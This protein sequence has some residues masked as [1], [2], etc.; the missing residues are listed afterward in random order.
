[1]LTQRRSRSLEF[2]GLSL[3]AFLSLNLDF[4][5]TAGLSF[6]IRPSRRRDQIRFRIGV[7]A[8]AFN[9]E[10]A[11]AER[12]PHLPQQTEFIVAARVLA[13]LLQRVLQPFL[14]EE[15]ARRVVRY[16][17]QTC[18]IQLL[19]D[20]DGFQQRFIFISGPPFK[21]LEELRSKL[22]DI[23]IARAEQIEVRIVEWACDLL[24]F[25]HGDS[26]LL[27]RDFLINR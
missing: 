24:A 7:T 19:Q 22:P 2:R 8:A 20:G 3:Q 5:Q 21:R 25:I 1:M 13:I 11:I 6:E 27:W 15:F 23:T 4:H 9:P 10:I 18:G 12:R 17:A 26:Q 14:W 16:L